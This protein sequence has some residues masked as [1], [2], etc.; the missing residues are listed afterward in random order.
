MLPRVFSRGQAIRVGLTLYRFSVLILSSERVLWEL[1]ETRSMRF[2]RSGGRALCV[3]GSVRF[4]R[5]R[6]FVSTLTTEL[7][8]VVGSAIGLTRVER[9]VETSAPTTWTVSDI[10][11]EV[12]PRAPV[13]G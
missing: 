5:L 3:R 10:Q 7:G 8:H 2:P 9:P 4:H 1:W 6:A 12:A 13:Q 11:W